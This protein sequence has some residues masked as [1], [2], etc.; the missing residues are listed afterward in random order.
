MEFTTVPSRFGKETA[1][2][3]NLNDIAKKSLLQKTPES[4]REQNKMAFSPANSSKLANMDCDFSQISEFM[5][6]E[7]K[8]EIKK[9]MVGRKKLITNFVSPRPN[10][11]NSIM[12]C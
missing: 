12:A 9:K 4:A 11:R 1:A 2:S 7:I 8:H 5:P 3:L 6:E 10:L